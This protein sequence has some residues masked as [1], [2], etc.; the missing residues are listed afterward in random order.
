MMKKRIAYIFDTAQQARFHEDALFALRRLNA[1]YNPI[2][3]RLAYEYAVNQ[4][5]GIKS[6]RGQG[7]G[8]KEDESVRK[9]KVYISRD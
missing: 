9:V 7:K 5:D 2:N 6:I 8:N 3:Y 1:N 4:N